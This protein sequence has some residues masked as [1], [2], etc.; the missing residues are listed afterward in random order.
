MNNVIKFTMAAG[1]L[2]LLGCTDSNV[3]GAAIEGNAVAQNSSS[4][5]ANG[6]SN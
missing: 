2:A 4:S 6:S 5:K 1:V 3:S